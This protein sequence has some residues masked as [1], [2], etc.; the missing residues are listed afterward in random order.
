M[1]HLSANSAF[2]WVFLTALFSTHLAFANSQGT[3][4]LSGRVSDQ[5]GGS[6]AFATVILMDG[7]RS[8]KETVTKED[9]TY[10]FTG[11]PPGHYGIRVT[12]NGFAS[13]EGS[14]FDLGPTRSKVLNLTLNVESLK[15]EIDV[16]SESVGTLNTERDANA[17][18]TIVT[19][20]QLD[21]LPDDPDDLQADLRAL[22][23][24]GTGPDGP[25]FI[26]DGFT[27][28]RLAPKESI[29][30]VRI[31]RDPFSAERDQL[32]Y[33]RIEIFT[34]PGSAKLH[35]QAFF[36]IDDS[37][38][39]SR[40]PYA[41]NK[42][43]VQARRYGGNV[44]GL[45]TQ[46]LSYFLDFER[47]TIGDSAVINAMVLDST[48]HP[49]ALREAV[50][51][52][53]S[54]TS[55]SSRLDYQWNAKN[56]LTGRYSW[57]DS[58]EENAGVGKISLLSNAYRSRVSDRTLQLSATSVLSSRIIN[59][60]RFQ[61][62]VY[63]T[64]FSG[65]NAAPAISVLD[66]F[67]GGG[68]TVGPSSSH[69]H[70]FE[71]QDYASISLRA[72]TLRFG[73]RVRTALLKDASAQ[74]FNGNFVFAGGSAPR[75]DASDQLILDSSGHPSSVPITSLERYRRTLVFSQRGLPDSAIRALGGGASQLLLAGGNPVT[76]LYQTDAGLFVEDTWRIRSN[77]SLGIGLRYE[78]QNHLADRMDLA[79]R[80]SLAWA[81]GARERKKP[82]MAIRLGSGLF[83]DRFSN[84]LTLQ[85]LRF[86]G[87]KQQQV[88]VKDPSFFP[89]V[90][91]LADLG[92]FHPIQT[93]RL[94]DSGLRAPAIMQSAA[95]VEFQLP[96]KNILSVTYLNTWGMHLLRSRNINAPI[97]AIRL[98]ES[99]FGS[100]RPLGVG[101]IFAYESTGVL[102]QNQILAK[103][104]SRVGQEFF[105]FAQYAYSQA[106]S[107]TDGPGSFPAN[108]FDLSAEYGRSG[109]DV[110]HRFSLS[111]TAKGPLGMQISPFIIVRS[112]L[113]FNITTG[114]DTNGDSL[115]TDRPAL[116]T[117]LSKP[118][119]VV[120]R[121][122]AFDPNLFA[123]QSIIPRNF[124]SG[125]A[126]FTLSLRLS[127]EFSFGRLTMPLKP[128]R[129]YKLRL[130]VSVRNLLNA[131]NP[132][133][134]IGNLGSPLFG[135][136]NSIA[137][138]S[139]P[140]RQAGNNR[141]FDFQAL[142]T[143]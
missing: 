139:G 26:V 126:Y 6:I 31:N 36:N 87:S 110:R 92:P 124:G 16:N 55:V 46:H 70:H 14:L 10:Q 111:G 24:P 53:R 71:V 77:L 65:D 97:P 30:E 120:T 108:Q 19:G 72:H 54:R 61:H 41:S 121:F 84:N 63:R 135:S 89:Q 69:R 119:V 136:S 142:F 105:M 137:Y 67:T 18:G 27:G 23:G 11:L 82:G 9:G 1:K 52:P 79:P 76:S 115:F 132:G 20:K 113:P 99:G 78:V 22:A 96:G 129:Q 123:S 80:L 17:D 21:A 64:K 104:E 59:E 100:V 13:E 58:Y 38:L 118:G 109:T 134:P 68:V 141:S 60:L 25:Q 57:F 131:V 98:L 73:A 48:F 103:I 112:G 66:S 95:G 86:N 94:T 39:N 32:G 143:F 122:G 116:A 140:D 45:L 74:T 49:L 35:G 90:P 47:R 7:Q 138:S 56:T 127:R 37:T 15:E 117:D 75:L 29:R 125:P 91:A 93:I 133:L 34:N 8:V 88:I 114:R 43:G 83:Y 51:D 2:A 42:P 12:A 40:N 50:F 102:N 4:T 106:F 44:T 3:A 5:S 62:L 33:G 107:D 128:E 85:T 28:A 130:S 81:P 101:N